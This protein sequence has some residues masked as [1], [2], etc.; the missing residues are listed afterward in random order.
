MLE[1]NIKDV[2][3]KKKEKKKGDKYSLETGAQLHDAHILRLRVQSAG[4]LFGSK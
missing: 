2:I 4:R 3:K 1:T